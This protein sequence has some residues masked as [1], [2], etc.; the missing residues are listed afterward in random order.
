MRQRIVLSV[1]T[2]TAAIYNDILRIFVSPTVPKRIVEKEWTVTTAR[3]HYTQRMRKVGGATI[4]A[5]RLAD[6]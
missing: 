3:A 2:S 5:H 6:V 1:Y 4:R